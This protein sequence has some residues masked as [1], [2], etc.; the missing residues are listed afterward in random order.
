MGRCRAIHNRRR[1]TLQ[2]TSLQLRREM[3]RLPT[4]HRYWGWRFGADPLHR[5]A[6]GSQCKGHAQWKYDL[7]N[8]SNQAI[9]D[10]ANQC[11]IRCPRDILQHPRRRPV[12]L[13][14]AEHLLQ[15]PRPANPEAHHRRRPRPYHQ[16][17]RNTRSGSFAAGTAGRCA[18]RL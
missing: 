16:R 10:D 1:S 2:P 13:H 15:H 8:L 12:R 4:S 6:G 5:R 9:D 11:R 18:A 17:G 3:D 14:R 7:V